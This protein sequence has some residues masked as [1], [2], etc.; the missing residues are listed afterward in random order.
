MMGHGKGTVIGFIAR[1]THN[2]ETILVTQNFIT[3][4]SY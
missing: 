1:V 2:P 4:Y 3:S